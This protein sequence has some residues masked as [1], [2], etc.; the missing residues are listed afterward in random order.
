MREVT[1]RTAHLPDP[2]V[3]EIP[4]VLEETEERALELPRRALVGEADALTQV[5]SVHHLP[6]NI[7]L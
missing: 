4:V 2:F 5:E 7:E 1:A 6:I 3:R